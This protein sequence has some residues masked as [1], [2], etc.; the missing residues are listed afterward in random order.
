MSSTRIWILAASVGLISAVITPTFG[1]NQ[2]EESRESTIQMSQVPQAAVDA[3]RRALGTAPT[4]AKIVRGTRP[5]EYELE[6]ESKGGKERS[7]HVLANGKVVKHEREE[8]EE[9]REQK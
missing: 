9:E 4:E 3:A 6:V 7:V 5:Q 2:R 1:Q 8:A